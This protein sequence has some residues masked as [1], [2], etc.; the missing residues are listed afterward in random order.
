[1]LELELVRAWLP[2]VVGVLL[3]LIVE[4]VVRRRDLMV[5]L[6]ITVFAFAATLVLLFADL[7][8]SPPTGQGMY[9]GSLHVDR[10]SIGISLVAV[11]LGL[12]ASILSHSYIQKIRAGH[13]E[14]YALIM[15]S[16]LGVIVLAQANDMFTFFL[17]FELMSIPV[18]ILAA[19]NRYS[20]RSNEAGM[21]YFVLGAFSTAFMLFGLALLFGAANSVMFDDVATMLGQVQLQIEQAGSESGLLSLASLD[22]PH[23]VL[24]LLG[25]VLILVGVLFKVGAFPFHTWV[26]DVYQGAPSSV[27]AFMGS[28]IK[29]GGFIVVLRLFVDT[30]NVAFL[31]ENW[32]PLMVGAAWLSMAWGNFLALRQTDVKR[33]LAYS[34]IAHTGYLLLVPIAL[35]A[36]TVPELSGVSAGQLNLADLTSGFTFYLLAYG[37]VTVGIFAAMLAFSSHADQEYLSFN[38][39]RGLGRRS[40]FLGALTTLFLISM[41]GIPATAGF[42][43]KLQVFLGVFGS[44][45]SSGWGILQTSVLLAILFSIVSLAYYLRLSLRLFGDPDPTKGT[46]KLSPY[47]NYSLVALIAGLLTLVLGFLPGLVDGLLS[48]DSMIASR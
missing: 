18:Y 29:V 5:P 1:M 21:K 10:F 42:M 28:V 41:A 44:A 43:A 14:Y 25:V 30:F 15:I 45:E 40:P 48:L 34:S 19:F 32:F 22:T 37:I 7:M 11:V 39:F 38:D 35:V 9:G 6:T 4:A 24:S 17:A 16:T 3:V 26:P 47:W 23:A 13:G 8:G 36:A 33:M 31:V 27:T 20:T 2:L 12:L 46:A